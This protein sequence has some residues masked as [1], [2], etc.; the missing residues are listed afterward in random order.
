MAA[1][2]SQIELSSGGSEWLLVLPGNAGALGGP[3]AGNLASLDPVTLAINWV[4]VLPAEAQYGLHALRSETLRSAWLLSGSSTLLTLPT[5][6]TAG[7]TIS[8]PAPLS[9]FGQIV[10]GE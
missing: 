10:I 6:P 8:H 4:E 5:D 1:G 9:A 3:V 2:T 7:P